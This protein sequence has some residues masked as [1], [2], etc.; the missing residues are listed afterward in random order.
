MG[1]EPRVANAAGPANG[2]LFGKELMLNR[3]LLICVFLLSALGLSSAAVAMTVEP[4]VINLGASGRNASQVVRVQNTF[5]TAELRVEELSLDANGVKSTGKDP[6][7]LVVFPPQRVIQPGQTQSFRIQYVG[8]PAMARSKH[9]YVTIAQLP[10]K[11]PAGQ[12]SI[13]VLYNFQVLVSVS[14]TGAKPSLKVMK[15]EIARNAAG[16]PVAALT[17]TNSSAA[18][19]YFSDGQLR[20]VQRDAAGK[21]VFRKTYTGP[22]I[23]QM[24]GFG[25]VGAGHT[26]RLTMPVELPVNG[27][28]LEAEYKPAG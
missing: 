24:L 25:L 6:G 1:A 14:P 20:L 16:R 5:A 17:V 21:E 23:Q 7:D 9:Y 11:M 22:E 26:R 3:F 18:H 12:S 15:T 28:R 2:N 8:D 4:V 19:G 13:Q 10:V 27:G